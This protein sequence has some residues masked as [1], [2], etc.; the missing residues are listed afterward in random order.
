VYREGREEGRVQG[1]REAI[2]RLARTRFGR[3]APELEA[4][5]ATMTRE[6]D[7]TALVERVGQAQSEAE[8]LAP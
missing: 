5:L 7:L 8:L 2:E 1:L 3:V 6:E 4:R